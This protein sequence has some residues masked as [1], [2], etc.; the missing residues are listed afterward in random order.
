MR[1]LILSAIAVATMFSTA[2]AQDSTM[3]EEAEEA[4]LEF[5]GSVDTYYMQ[6][7]KS[8]STNTAFTT[9]NNG[10]NLGM[11]NL[12]A[13]KDGEKAGFVADLVFGPRGD[14]AVF[15]DVGNPAILNQL[16]GYY[17][18][19]DKVTLTLGN[20]NTFLGYEVI[21][22]AA[23]FNYSTSYMFSWGPFSHTGLKAD[24]S[25]TDDITFMAGVMN[26]TDVTSTALTGDTLF[27]GFQL[28]L[29]DAAWI[30]V[31]TGPGYMQ[32]DLTAGT[33]VTDDFYLGVNATYAAS[34]DGGADADGNVAD[35]G[36]YGAALY[37]QYALSDAFALGVRGEYFGEF[38]GGYGIVGGYTDA[39]ANIID[40]T[41]SANIDLG[42]F[43]LIPEVRID[44]ASEDV[45]MDSDGAATSSLPS[46]F[47]AGV[48]AF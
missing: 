24:I 32:F 29:Y 42:G 28:G 47:L 46:F 4:K 5:S 40:L 31:L 14:A 8:Q 1:K 23:N 38:N 18:V 45:F 21:S 44:M 3:T 7:V 12:I 35:A 36:F 10:F 39:A 33:N 6:S 13:S 20:F 25:I 27:L 16:Y 22:P 30:N 15:G 43:M 26:E 11:V 48:Y 19:S 37:A 2:N 17:N 34:T 9:G 41:L